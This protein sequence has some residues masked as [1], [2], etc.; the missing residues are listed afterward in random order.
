[1]S[2]FKCGHKGVCLDG[3]YLWKEAV[4]GNFQ[5]DEMMDRTRRKS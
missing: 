2:V 5:K 3:I 4:Q 1:M